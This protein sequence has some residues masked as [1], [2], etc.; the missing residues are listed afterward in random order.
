MHKI[1]DIIG[2][3]QPRLSKL[4]RGQDVME[5]IKASLNEIDLLK[6]YI[7]H[8]KI[9]KF[10]QGIVYFSLSS[11]ALA[12]QIRHSSVMILQSLRHKLPET[13]FNAIQCSVTT[14]TP[15]SIKEA[16][17]RKNK[18]TALSKKTKADL[19]RLSEKIDSKELSAALKKLV[20]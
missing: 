15:S 1:S 4:M 6:K 3:T 20:N 11:A 8:Y 13:E 12:T 9:I 10:S 2:N 17:Y 16:I 18:P 7:A 5:K 14:N 19:T